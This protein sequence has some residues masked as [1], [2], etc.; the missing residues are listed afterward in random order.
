MSQRI[1]VKHKNKANKEENENTRFNE[2]RQFA[3]FFGAE[4]ERVL[5]KPINYMIQYQ[6]AITPL[7]IGMEF[8]K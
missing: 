8:L 7:Y 4:R 6:G 5:I 2:V 3:Y 1:S